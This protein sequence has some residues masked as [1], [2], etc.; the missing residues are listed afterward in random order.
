M[1]NVYPVSL[2]CH[3]S[4][5]IFIFSQHENKY[6]HFSDIHDATIIYY[7][8]PK[9]NNHISSIL[10]NDM[11][12]LLSPDIIIIFFQSALILMCSKQCVCNQAVPRVYLTITSIESIQRIIDIMFLS[13]ILIYASSIFYSSLNYNRGFANFTQKSFLKSLKI[14]ISCGWTLK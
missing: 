10:H 5:T 14:L 9:F 7:S 3:T 6:S 4:E 2:I 12:R 11:R 1:K 13:L 8:S